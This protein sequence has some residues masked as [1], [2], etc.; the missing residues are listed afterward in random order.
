MKL[1]F[2]SVLV[3]SQKFPCMR[4][5]LPELPVEPVNKLVLGPFLIVGLRV[6]Q[7]NRILA[8]LSIDETKRSGSCRPMNS[9][10]K[11]KITHKAALCPNL[12][13]FRRNILREHRQLHGYVVPLGHF[14]EGDTEK[15]LFCPF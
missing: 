3:Y 10:I 15:F 12:E 14:P 8:L 1:I 9:R 2:L 11:D 13:G 4:M 6:E 7:I 5:G